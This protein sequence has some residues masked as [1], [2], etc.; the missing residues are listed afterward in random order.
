[1]YRALNCNLPPAQIPELLHRPSPLS[2]HPLSDSVRVQEHP[3]PLTGLELHQEQLGLH[4]QPVRG[5]GHGRPV[6]RVEYNS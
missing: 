2:R 3:R 6:R 1:M 5:A 4:Q